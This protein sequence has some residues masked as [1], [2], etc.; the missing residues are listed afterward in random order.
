MLNEMQNDA[1]SKH[2]IDLLKKCKIYGS[3]EIQSYITKNGES[4]TIPQRELF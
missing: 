2:A 3:K 4:Y 1:D